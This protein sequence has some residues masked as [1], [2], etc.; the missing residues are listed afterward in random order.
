MA[1]TSNSSR[2]NSYLPSIVRFDET[3]ENNNQDASS[4]TQESS[5]ERWS[6]GPDA[7]SEITVLMDKIQRADAEA[8]GCPQLI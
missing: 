4:D 5:Q 3:N 8:K 1:N 2:I 6:D 7:E